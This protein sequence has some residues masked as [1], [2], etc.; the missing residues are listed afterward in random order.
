MSD[1]ERGVY[2]KFV[3]QRTDGSLKHQDCCYFVLD[4]NHDP[5]AVPALEAYA[6]ACRE[7]YPKLADDI[8]L[9]LATAEP[10]LELKKLF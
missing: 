6:K 4:L 2:S 1:Q 10:A 3:V 7:L 8:E 9:A 5:F